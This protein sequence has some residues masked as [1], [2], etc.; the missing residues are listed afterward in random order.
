[1]QALPSIGERL[2][3]RRLHIGEME[4]GVLLILCFLVLASTGNQRISII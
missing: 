4:Y 2:V 3:R 1:M